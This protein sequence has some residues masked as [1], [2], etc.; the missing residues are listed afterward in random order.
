MTGSNG[1]AIIML[2]KEGH[3]KFGF[4]TLEERDYFETSDAE[5]MVLK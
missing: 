5:K 1:Q 3:K 4:E 2:G